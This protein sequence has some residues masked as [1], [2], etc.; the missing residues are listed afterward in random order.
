MVENRWETSP[1]LDGG[2]LCIKAMAKSC[3][4]R[5]D[6]ASGWLDGLGTIKLFGA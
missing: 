3:V 6:G 4:S 1:G 2:G 5:A